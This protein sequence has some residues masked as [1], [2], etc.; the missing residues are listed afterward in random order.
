[1]GSRRWDG[2][3]RE[4][5]RERDYK[6]V[7]TPQPA[8]AAVADQYRQSS[9][10]FSPSPFPLLT[11]TYIHSGRYHP[12]LSSFRREGRGQGLRSGRERGGNSTKFHLPEG[13][14]R[15]RDETS[16]HCQRRREEGTNLT[17]SFRWR[18]PFLFPLFWKSDERVGSLS[19]PSFSQPIGS[20]ATAGLQPSSQ[21]HEMRGRDD[22][23]EKR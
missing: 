20:H 21:T 3:R 8:A 5:E 10:S 19:I 4:R 17:P 23:D 2:E 1:M 15:E 18:V 22:D 11:L 7:P 9:S 16:S 14:E 12:K 13:G 6:R